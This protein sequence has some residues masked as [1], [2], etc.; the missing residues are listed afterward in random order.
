MVAAVAAIA[1]IKCWTKIGDRWI[2]PGESVVEPIVEIL[3]VAAA[4]LI[5]YWAAG[6]RRCSRKKDSSSGGSAGTGFWGW[7]GGD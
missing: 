6:C 5:F 1:V 2:L 4:V 7:G 3:I